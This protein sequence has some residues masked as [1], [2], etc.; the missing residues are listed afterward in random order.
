MRSRDGMQTVCVVCEDTKAKSSIPAVQTTKKY[1]Q[2]VGTTFNSELISTSVPADISGN[3]VSARMTSNIVSLLNSSLHS[4]DSTQS[5]D[6]F[7]DILES[8]LPLLKL[9]ISLSSSMIGEVKSK[10][11]ERLQRPLQSN[12]SRAAINYFKLMKRLLD[13]L[14]ELDTIK[15]IE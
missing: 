13:A 9:S 7:V 1:A 3:N 10:I 11:G 6:T 8:A 14:I 12:D 5:L 15:M 4:S 2:T